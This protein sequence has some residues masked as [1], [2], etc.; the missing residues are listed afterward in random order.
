MSIISEMKN[1][2]RNYKVSK[3]YQ[4]AGNLSKAMIVQTVEKE[5]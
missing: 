4:E 5:I 2:L 1:F 3:L